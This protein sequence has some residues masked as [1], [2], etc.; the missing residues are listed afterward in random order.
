MMTAFLS[1]MNFGGI[2]HIFALLTQ[3]DQI[4]V[5]N[6]II[7]LQLMLVLTNLATQ[8]YESKTKNKTKNRE[9]NQKLIQ[10]K[11]KRAI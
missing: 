4:S 7:T 3:I 2:V 1:F 11:N 5:C 10:I 6:Q 8:S 9:F